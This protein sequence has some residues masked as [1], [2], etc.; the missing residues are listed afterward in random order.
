MNPNPI[1]RDQAKAG[2]AG[3]ECTM[4][5]RF[6]GQRCCHATIDHVKLPAAHSSSKRRNLTGA[7]KRLGP[8]IRVGWCFNTDREFSEADCLVKAG[9]D[10][11]VAAQLI[12]N[13]TAAPGSIQGISERLP[14]HSSQSF[15][16][17]SHASTDTQKRRHRLAK[18]SQEL[19]RLGQGGG[20]RD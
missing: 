8:F 7:P 12:A 16:S 3:A 10:S 15:Q 6:G 1:Y 13:H 11:R 5:K 19:V 17:S 9:V 14:F 2:S 18:L 4:A 20:G